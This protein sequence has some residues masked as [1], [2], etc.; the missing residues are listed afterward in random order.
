MK[1]EIAQSNINYDCLLQQKCL[2]STV[3]V[4]GLFSLQ[5]WQGKNATV[6]T[7]GGDRHIDSHANRKNFMSRL[8]RNDWP[9]YWA[10]FDDPALL[11]HKSMNI[12]QTL[13]EIEEEL[14]IKLLSGDQ[15]QVIEALEER[16]KEMSK[17]RKP[18]DSGQ[19]SLFD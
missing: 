19:I 6:G 12:D 1:T 10:R 2:N 4:L 7:Q 14:D 5:N 9:G 18:V 11:Q 17:R 8:F 3:G 15:I 16:L 13:R